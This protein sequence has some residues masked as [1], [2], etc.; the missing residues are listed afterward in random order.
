MPR[1][2]PVHWR[3]LVRV[4]EACGYS[5]DRTAGSH[6]VMTKPGS[7]R[8]VVVPRHRRVAVSII[9]SNMRTAGLSRER[10]FELLRS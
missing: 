10:Y 7:D 3:R 4:F 1:I 8:P 6:L 9:Q 5:E 2:T